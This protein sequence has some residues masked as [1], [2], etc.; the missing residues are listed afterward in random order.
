MPTVETGPWVQV[1]RL[2]NPLF[3]EVL[4]PL[5]RKDEWNASAPS[6]D[7]AYA[8]GVAQPELAKLLPGLY[9]GVFPHLGAYTKPRAD[10]LAILLTGIPPAS[11]RRR[12]P[13]TPAA[14][15]PTSCA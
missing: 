5:G 12:S 9:P 11:S 13:P 15:R 4:V 2:G 1:S 10:L 14:S 8:A 6:G 3:N 7:S